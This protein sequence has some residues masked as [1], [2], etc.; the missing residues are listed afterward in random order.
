MSFHDT[1]SRLRDYLS[2]KAAAVPDS[3]GPPGLVTIPTRR[4]TWPVLAAAAAI[5]AVL[6]LTVPL[7]VRLSDQPPAAGP[8]GP[9]PISVPYIL[10]KDRTLYDGSTKVPLPGDGYRYSMIGRAASG[11]LV[12]KTKPEPAARGIRTWVGI[13][14]KSGQFLPRGSGNMAEGALSPDRKRAVVREDGWGG[15]PETRLVVVDLESG[16]RL[17]TLTP[18]YYAE[19]TGWNNRGIWYVERRAGFQQGAFVWEPGQSRGRLIPVADIEGG[20]DATRGTDRLIMTTSPGRELCA[21]VVAPRGTSAFETLVEICDDLGSDNA[22][23]SRA[24]LS[25]DGRFL[26]LLGLK[27]AIEVDTERTTRLDKMPFALG[28]FDDIVFEDAENLLLRETRVVDAARSGNGTPTPAGL[29]ELHDRHKNEPS[30]LYR[31]N[32]ESGSCEI[33]HRSTGGLS[34]GQP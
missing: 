22:M 13:L 34:L 28:W 10:E 33:V 31:C 6:T 5:A 30:N 32:V 25:P 14:T 4:R 9:V 27:A 23:L 26:V 1:E 12:K 24:T 7:L 15:K 17:H 19:L 20:Y 8:A 3:A 18:L 2:E 16:E 11:W 29:A 21:K